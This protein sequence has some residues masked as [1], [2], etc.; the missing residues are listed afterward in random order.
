ML[1]F[2]KLSFKRRIADKEFAPP[3]R[4]ELAAR[5]VWPGI[6]IPGAINNRDSFIPIPFSSSTYPLT[7]RHFPLTGY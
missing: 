4:E 6:K 3:R 2:T 5:R 1:F 7:T